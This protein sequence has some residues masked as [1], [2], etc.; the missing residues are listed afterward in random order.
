MLHLLLHVTKLYHINSRKDLLSRDI[1][2]FLFQRQNKIHRLKTELEMWLVPVCE[3]TP[4]LGTSESEM[5]GLQ[6]T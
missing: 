5:T 2:P 4:L 3:V 6:H 1:G